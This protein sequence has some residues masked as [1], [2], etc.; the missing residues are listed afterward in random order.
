M[1]RVALFDNRLRPRSTGIKR[2]RARASRGQA[3]VIQLDEK[4]AT[5]S[6]EAGRRL[7]FDTDAII[8]GATNALL[9]AEVTLS[10]LCRDMSK[11]EL[12][13]LQLS[14][15]GVTELRARAP[16]VVRSETSEARLCGIQ[17]DY[18]P[19]D[20]LRYTS[21]QHLPALQTQRN[22]LPE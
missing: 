20:A 10:G 21:P 7:R 1:M 18:V 12:N 4:S 15:C 13:L 11:Q 14:S 17:L 3:E 6:F 5:R 22:I 2:Q 8:D 19:D 16:Q 9:A